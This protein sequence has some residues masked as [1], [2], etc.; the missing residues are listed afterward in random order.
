MGVVVHD[1]QVFC[2]SFRAGALVCGHKASDVVVL[3]QRQ[4]VDGAFVQEVLTVGRGEHLHGDRPLVQRATVH[5]A[6]PATA[7]QLE[8]QSWWGG[9]GGGETVNTLLS[10]ALSCLIKSYKLLGH[11]QIV[12]QIKRSKRRSGTN[13]NKDKQAGRGE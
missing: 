1:Q 2:A 3:Q 8:Q 11:R 5:C 10:L 6:V 9:G 7:N 13:I 12:L 4:P